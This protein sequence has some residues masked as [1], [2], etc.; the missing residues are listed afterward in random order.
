MT[1][2]STSDPRGNSPFKNP[3]PVKHPITLRAI[4]IGIIFIPIVCLWVEYTEIVAQATDLAAM[5]LPIAVVFVLV[6]VIC[7]NLFLRKYLPRYAFSQ[8]EILYIFIM[9]TVSIGIC[10]IGMMQFLNTEVADIFY[11]STPENKWGTQILP[12]IKPWLLPDKRVLHGYFAGGERFMTLSILRGWITPILVWSAFIIIAL[13]VMLCLNVIIRRQWIDQE[14]LSFPITAI[15]LELTRD[16]SL[17]SLL[18]NKLL[19]IGFTIPVIL[20][21]LASLNYLYPSVPF[22]PIK[23]SDPRLILNSLFTTSPWTGMG[24]TVLSFYPMVIGLT[25]FIP[26]DVGFSLWFFYLFTKAENVVATALGYHD[27]GASLAASRMP[28]IGEQSAGAFIAI[29]LFTLYT[30]RGNIMDALRKTFKHTPDVRDMNEPFSYRWAVLGTIGG[31][32]ALTGFAMAIGMTWYVP[33]IFFFLY[34]LFIIT[35]TRIRAEAGLAWGYGPYLDPHSMMMSATG[36]SAYNKQTLL[37]F[38]S[39]LWFDLDYRC[40]AMPAQLEAMKISESAKM[41][42]KHIALAIIIATVVGAF[43]SWWAV[44]TCY[45][46]YGAATAQVNSWRTSMGLVPWQTVSTWL[47]SPAK[48]ELSRMEGVGIGVVVCAF[49]MFMR[50]RFTW[51]PFHPIG[52]AVSGTETM[53]WL[54]CATLIG[55][56]LKL[57]IIRYGGMKNFRKGIPFFIGLIIG[58]YLTGSLWSIFGSITGITTYRVFPI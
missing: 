41:N 35:F 36:V 16:D 33:L 30:M 12:F 25:Y 57:L 37:G 20:E 53:H 40:N 21:T 31:Y 17:K 18:S 32:L 47:N 34:Y 2:P 43:A 4:I 55:W 58:D 46:Q 44:L 52:Y 56:L 13:G 22:I 5:S 14:R 10:G 28:Y 39:I 26:L 49:L 48:Q 11:Y 15:P 42:N 51:W 45:Y 38:A 24:D 3:T 29:A 9:Q 7:A 1:Q 6:L 27:P 23:P 8:A 19:W 54:W 50:T